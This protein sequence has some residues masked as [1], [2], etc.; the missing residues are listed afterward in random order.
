MAN[1]RATVLIV[2]D[3]KGMRDL[4][5]F[6]L[7]TE[8]YHT[9]EATNGQEAVQCMVDEAFEVVIAD[10]MMPGMNGLEL[11]QR[12]RDRD[13]EA[14][15]IVM[16]AYASLQTAIEAMKYGAYDYLIKPFNDVEKVINIVARAVER[17]RLARRNARLLKDLKAA[18][19]RLNEMFVE[20]QDRTAQLEAAYEELKE[21][22]HLKSQFVSTISQQLRT[23]LSLLKG[24]MTLMED[25]LLAHMT[26]EQS[27]ALEM[28]SERTDSLIQFV[29]D[30]LLV[31]D[32]ESDKAYLCLEAVSLADLV[33]QVCQ[34]ME[35]R[36]QRK[37]MA[38]QVAIGRNGDEAIPAIQGDAI[39]LEQALTHLLDNAIWF[40]PPSSSIS[41]ELGV[42]GQN[43]YL[44][45]RHQ[46]EG[47]SPESLARDYSF[48]QINL[49]ARRQ[50]G[51]LGLL[52]VKHIAEMHGGDV[53]VINDPAAGTTLC[54]ILP[55]EDKGRLLHQSM[56]LNSDW[57]D[58]FR[59][60]LGVFVVPQPALQ[61]T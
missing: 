22:D 7:R 23:P 61:P 25:H 10:I 27:W 48:Y 50:T 24:Y 5:S 39:R 21:L 29:D 35:S 31:Q 6:M 1:E 44:S 58:Q 2:D 12:I 18:N 11:L 37:G 45:V 60:S 3:E 13:D 16:T 38:L 36:A 42:R 9:I 59:A 8:G 57:A 43:L 52:L 17:C 41:V 46:G 56:A 19:R 14:A 4:L 55:L 40:G 28:V 51:E 47:V 30:I 32:I 15:V 20:S 26:E 33:Q 53:T 34:R 54:L 49:Q